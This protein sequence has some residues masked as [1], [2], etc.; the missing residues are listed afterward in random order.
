MADSSPPISRI[1][2]LKVSIFQHSR[3]RP[4]SNT[5][6]FRCSSID[7]VFWLPTPPYLSMLLPALSSASSASTLSLQFPSSSNGSS[8]QV[9]G[10]S[11][12][13]TYGF[14]FRLLYGFAPCPTRTLNPRSPTLHHVSP[15]STRGAVPRLPL[16]STSSKL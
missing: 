9:T 10:Q 16:R 11:S 8:T 4:S 15:V 5:G 13:A 7:L 2:L 3:T 1:S 14:G 12:A 6:L